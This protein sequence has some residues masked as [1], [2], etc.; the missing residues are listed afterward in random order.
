MLSFDKKA[1]KSDLDQLSVTYASL[2][3]T[4]YIVNQHIA[5]AEPLQKKITEMGNRVDEIKSR[6][7]SERGMWH[8][9]HSATKK[10]S[11]LIEELYRYNHDNFLPYPDRDASSSEEKPLGKKR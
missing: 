1:S 9:I 8:D 3:E 6:S 5:I 10:C 11:K 7:L 2:I 4:H